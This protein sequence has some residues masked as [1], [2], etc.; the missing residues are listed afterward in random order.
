MLTQTDRPHSSNRVQS[1]M[2][3]TILAIAVYIHATAQAT[4]DN[5][6]VDL[7]IEE[8]K[9][10]KR[11][12]F[13]QKMME[14][15]EKGS[16]KEIKRTTE[17]GLPETIRKIDLRSVEKR[18]RHPVY[19]KAC[20][21]ALSQD[22]QHPCC[23]DSVEIDFHKLGWNFIISPRTIQYKF[24]MGSCNPEFVRQALFTPAAAQVLYVSAIKNYFGFEYNENQEEDHKIYFSF[25]E[26]SSHEWNAH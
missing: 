23:T 16:T 12:F 11:D 8:W 13:L 24:C 1:E 14:Q 3:K 22:K 21:A 7:N 6:V 19:T 25:P 10:L 5:T 20:P 4:H 17:A 9:V 2:I 15:L 18:A 26:A